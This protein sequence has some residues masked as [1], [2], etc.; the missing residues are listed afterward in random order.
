MTLCITVTP[1]LNFEHMCLTIHGDLAL[2]DGR[3]AVDASPIDEYKA[4][5]PVA[6]GCENT[7]LRL[8]TGIL[9]CLIRYRDH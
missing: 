9:D 1:E 3:P 7:H 5:A 4:S 8:L 2:D 6:G